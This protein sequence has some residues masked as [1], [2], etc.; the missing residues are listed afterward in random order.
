MSN[1]IQ[2]KSDLYQSMPDNTGHLI[3]HITENS[4]S[5]AV[6]SSAAVLVVLVSKS[7]PENIVLHEFVEQ[8]LKENINL[9]SNHYQSVRIGVNTTSFT[10]LPNHITTH[11]KETMDFLTES[12]TRVTFSNQV[13]CL[14]S[15]LLFSIP[16][17]LKNVIDQHFER[18]DMIHCLSLAIKEFH[19]TKHQAVL[20]GSNSE[21]DCLVFKNEQLY[22]VNRHHFKTKED[23]LYFSL[24]SLKDA[25]IDAKEASAYLTGTFKKHSL[26][27]NVLYKYIQNVETGVKNSRISI[28]P[29]FNSSI[30]EHQYTLLLLN[31]SY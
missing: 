26:E 30:E 22:S 17:G 13:H 9:V 29:D 24:L 19:N 11:P 12:P 15:Q 10:L 14:N 5:I 3:I 20:I 28:R 2:Y 27:Y 7:K 1:T 23:L 25:D 6:A 18:Y 4:C 8:V 21:F 16:K 31:A